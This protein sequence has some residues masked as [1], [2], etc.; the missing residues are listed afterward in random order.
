M[1]L[2]TCTKNPFRK[3]R[4]LPFLGAE[5]KQIGANIKSGRSLRWGKCNEAQRVHK[6]L[7]CATFSPAYELIPAA[8][9]G[10]IDVLSYVEK[11]GAA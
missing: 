6:I 7:G 8:V 2:E 5:L 11:R 10:T 3:A 9:I 1:L 4:G